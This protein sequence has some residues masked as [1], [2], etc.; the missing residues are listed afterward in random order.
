[1]RTVG[2]ILKKVRLR[3]KL[4]LKE[5]EEKTKIKREYLSALEEDHYQDLPPSA[6]T[7]GFIK[8]Y[9]QILGLKP[10]PLL[11]IFRRDY[12]EKTKVT[13]YVNEVGRGFCWTPKLTITLVVVLTLLFFFGYLFRQYYSLF[14]P[15]PL[16][17][18]SPKENEVVTSEE[19][20]VFGKTKPEVDVFINNQR[21]FPSENGEFRKKLKMKKGRQTITIEVVNKRGKKRV[22]ERN[23]QVKLEG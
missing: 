16:R 11:A 8:N 14:T 23:F 4:T 10:E 1:M 15:P 6:Y 7:Q 2:E 19:V 3:K 17:L 18:Y 21:I 9:S 12:K 20:E 5:I 22:L 13:S